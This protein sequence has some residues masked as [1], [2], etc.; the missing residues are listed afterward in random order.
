MTTPTC[1][2]IACTNIVILGSRNVHCFCLQHD[3]DFDYWLAEIFD[4]KHIPKIAMPGLITAYID[5]KEKDLL[6]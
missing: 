3:Q 2:V 4:T 5:Q 6:G 1:K